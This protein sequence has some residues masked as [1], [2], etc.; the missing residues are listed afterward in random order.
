M[1]SI[2]LRVFLTV[3]AITA[4]I[5]VATLFVANNS[6]HYDFNTYIEHR[7]MHSM[8]HEDDDV[9]KDGKEPP[10]NGS[11]FESNPSFA[12]PQGG[13]NRRD[14][15]ANGLFGRFLPPPLPKGSNEQ[16]FLFDFRNSLFK[17]A[18][19][20]LVL[21]AGLSYLL[22]RTI[23]TPILILHKGVKKVGGGDL[24][25]QVLVKRKDEIG[26]LAD[27]FNEMT[28][29]LKQIHILRQ[30][31]LAGVAHELRTPLTIL[32]ANLEGI[33]DG[34]VAPTP[35]HIGSLLEEVDRLTRLV[36]ELKELTLLEV[37]KLT[38]NYE[39]VNINDIVLNLVNKMRL[40]SEHKGISMSATVDE[41]VG[42]I[43]A[44]TNMLD[45]MLLN[46]LMNAIKYTE[47]GS[48]LVT[49][50]EIDKT[51]YISIT[52]TGIGISETDI[53]HVFEQFYRADPSRNRKSGGT[54]LGLAIAR[55]MARAH[56]GDI[57]L[58]SEVGVGTTFTISI[59]CSKPSK[60]RNK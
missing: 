20:L 23:V 46:I 10:R 5:I 47:T 35:N 1:R 40:I 38:P 55:N 22:A 50:K 14:H 54:G 56:G 60:E 15:M 4:A 26:Q 25:V 52:D 11:L 48:V 18:A 28:S 24:D 9:M 59:P 57:T 58:V 43:D 45:H 44:D 39:K 27:S 7:S 49:T 3:F 17:M 42:L 53:P 36:E 51:L 34:V 16:Q 33:V 8:M 21:G 19:I 12:G 37:G 2:Q 13:D 31:F 41:H 29:Y 32:K 30:R 6:L